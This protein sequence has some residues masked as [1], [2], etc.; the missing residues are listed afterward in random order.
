MSKQSH[1]A[2]YL[3]L[4]L[5]IL[6]IGYS[7]I[8]SFHL[9]K[10]FKQDVLA[11]VLKVTSQ[12]KIEMFPE[13]LREID[14]R[15]TCSET[16]SYS[17]S[18]SSSSS[19]SSSDNMEDGTTIASNDLELEEFLSASHFY[20][21]Q[22]DK[23]NLESSDMKC[24]GTLFRLDIETDEWPVENDWLITNEDTN[25]VVMNVSYGQ[26]DFLKRITHEECLEPGPYIFELIDW[27]GDAIAC[28][29]S[30]PCYNITLN[31]E[32][33]IPGSLFSDYVSH[34]F[35]SSPSATCVVGDLFLLQVQQEDQLNDDEINSNNIAWQ[36]YQNDAVSSFDKVVFLQPTTAQNDKSIFTNEYFAC[37][38]PGLYTFE[39]IS[40]T[41]ATYHILIE[42][43][44]IVQETTLHQNDFVTHG[45]AVLLEGGAYERQCHMNPPL[46]P[47]NRISNF[48]YDERVEKVMNVVRSISSPNALNEFES[49]QY[50][51]ACWLLHDD[52]EQKQS[53][54][55]FMLQRYL[56]AVFL[57]A[58]K[59][60]AE[61][62]IPSDVCDSFGVTCND[63]GH[64]ISINFSECL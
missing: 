63:Q 58:S 36:L 55:Q 48:Q 37:L 20:E 59:L 31:N 4:A 10:G 8:I 44:I 19:Y 24:D 17:S 56:I 39:M 23:R 47:I 62:M 30:K 22:P 5:S 9:G 15:C 53:D 42:D 18:L 7:S 64:V 27:G 46:I 2:S 52:L 51:A 28:R 12:T 13:L 60:N 49:S 3:A 34:T 11:E 35:D 38:V 54:D 41:N 21:R 33:L 43:E 16:S 45:F 50:K 26:N 32:I 1:P 61:I 57:Y 14:A 40:H 6:S 29:D 25:S